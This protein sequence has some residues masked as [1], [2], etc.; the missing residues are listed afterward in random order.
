MRQPVTVGTK[1]RLLELSSEIGIDQLPD[2]EVADLLSMVG[3][4][5]EVTEVL[6]GR[7][8]IEKVWQETSGASRA[9]VLYLEA[10]EMEV[11][12]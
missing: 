6:F 1:V 9:H 5:F 10:H 4:V 3:E 7:A 8:C 11:V 12:A 2:D